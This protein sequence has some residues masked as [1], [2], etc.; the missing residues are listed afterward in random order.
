MENKDKIEE[1]FRDKAF[2]LE[3]IPSNKA[4]L[5][6][7]SKL[8][9]DTRRPSLQIY[10]TFG[11]MAASLALAFLAYT[12]VFVGQ[13]KEQN[14]W[15]MN[16]FGIVPTE[17]EVL[18]EET[19]SDYSNNIYAIVEYQKHYTPRAIHFNEGKVGQKIIANESEV[20]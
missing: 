5:R 1:L 19:E 7:E 20:R 17:I 10:R 9:K 4:W 14:R 8:D 6:L 15:A 16:E 2:K 3:S 13:N 18:S 12:A 11:L